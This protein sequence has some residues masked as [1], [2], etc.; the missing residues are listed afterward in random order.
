MP[1]FA[2][3]TLTIGLLAMFIVGCDSRPVVRV[4]TVPKGK[5]LA[6][7]PKQPAGQPVPRRILSAIIPSGTR[8]YYVKAT[9][10][11]SR[12]WIHSLSRSSK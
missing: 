10:D 5:E 9:E 3:A 8:V 7:Q 2:T 11:P 1:R 6:A 12:S 4:Y